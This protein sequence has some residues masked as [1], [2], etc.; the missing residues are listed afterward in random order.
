MRRC[1]WFLLYL[2]IS[3]PS[4]PLGYEVM[5]DIC[6]SFSHNSA[7]GLVVT[8]VT[9]HAGFVLLGARHDIAVDGDVRVG[10]S[11]ARAAILDHQCHGL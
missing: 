10:V 4:A 3:K 1:R 2:S 7:V 6:H 11:I 5:A 8:A 9:N